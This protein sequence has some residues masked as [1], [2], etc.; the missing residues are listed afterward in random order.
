M[1]KKIIIS[2][3]YEKRIKKCKILLVSEIVHLEFLKQNFVMTSIIFS[4]LS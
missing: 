2:Y 4:L 3:H 1:I